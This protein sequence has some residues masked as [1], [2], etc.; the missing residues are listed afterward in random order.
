MMKGEGGGGKE[1]GKWGGEGEG[2]ERYDHKSTV[3]G[4]SPCR[5]LNVSD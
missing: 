4:C 5:L 1:G 3:Y 2:R